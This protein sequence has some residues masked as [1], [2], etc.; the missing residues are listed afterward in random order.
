MQRVL[1]LDKHKEK[2]FKSIYEKDIANFLKYAELTIP[3]INDEDEKTN[4][5]PEVIT[6]L[7]S[8]NL[9]SFIHEFIKTKWFDAFKYN[10]F[11]IIL[12][13]HYN[14][15]ITVKTLI[16][17]GVNPASRSNCALF[18]AAQ[19]G[20]IE[21]VK[22]LLSYDSVLLYE[23]CDLPILMAEKFKRVG[24][25]EIIFNALPL[26]QKENFKNDNLEL[27]KKLSVEQKVLN[28]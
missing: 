25:P 8:Y 1:V 28:F 7:Y 11:L 6:K 19:Y 12:A 21:V 5:Y 3:N 23:P 10:S 14:D 13:A 27:Y 16:E 24:I 26:H 9:T 20:N 4:Y 2:L 18:R 15:L 22:L 17:L